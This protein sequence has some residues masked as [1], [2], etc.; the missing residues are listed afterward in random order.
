MKPIK[1]I[2]NLQARAKKTGVF[3]QLKT[4]PSIGLLKSK[5]E[6]KEK[7]RQ[8]ELARQVELRQK[9]ERAKNA[10]IDPVAKPA[11]E[12]K[13]KQVESTIGFLQRKNL[14]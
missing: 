8:R 9:L 12:T 6:S 5:Q 14:P 7:F 4:A 10:G 1:P 13:T 2:I 3:S 11:I